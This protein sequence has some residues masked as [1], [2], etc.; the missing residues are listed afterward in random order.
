MKRMI[1]PTLL[2]GPL[3]GLLLCLLL[4][5]P[6][7]AATQTSPPENQPDLELLEFLGAFEDRDTGWI[8]PFEMSL[9]DEGTNDDERLEKQSDER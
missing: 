5:G 4:H 2:A 1:F 7:R 6:A 8:D 9:G 3:I